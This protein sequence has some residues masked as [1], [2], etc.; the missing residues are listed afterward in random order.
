MRIYKT[1]S[2]LDAR[3]VWLVLPSHDDDV[4]PYVSLRKRFMMASWCVTPCPGER[5]SQRTSGL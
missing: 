2:A 3:P 5:G 1:R 4:L